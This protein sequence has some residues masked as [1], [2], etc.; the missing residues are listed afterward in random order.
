MTVFAFRVKAVK[1][2]QSN[3]TARLFVMK[4]IL[5]EMPKLAGTVQMSYG[6]WI[7]F[8]YCL[9]QAHT[10]DHEI[11]TLPDVEPGEDVVF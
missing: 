11:V 10:V 4:N 9:R 2:Q 6:E 8:N 7:A 1:G 5:D 3:I